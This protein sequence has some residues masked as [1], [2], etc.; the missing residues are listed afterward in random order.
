M[1]RGRPSAGRALTGG[2]PGRPGK[3]PD[4]QSGDLGEGETK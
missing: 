3:V 1:L 2:T 4:D